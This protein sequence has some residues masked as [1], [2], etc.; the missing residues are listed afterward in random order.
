MPK[1]C[2][3][4]GEPDF[5]AAILPFYAPLGQEEIVEQHRGLLQTSAEL[6][7]RV[8][9]EYLSVYAALG[10]CLDNFSVVNIDRYYP[11]QND[12]LLEIGREPVF[13]RPNVNMR[14]CKWPRDF[15]L[16]TPE[17]ALINPMALLK[18][19]QREPSVGEK[20]IYSVLGEGGGTLM[21]DGL[22]IT[23]RR[24]HDVEGWCL[25]ANKVRPLQDLAQMNVVLN[26]F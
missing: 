7:A 24:I 23:A 18:S 13:L 16:N 9:E 14:Y 15:C 17:L 19:H 11:E 10:H 26:T 3:V 21:A 25:A 1:T 8:K 12:P 20:W 22:V 6:K 5:E 2:F 4:L